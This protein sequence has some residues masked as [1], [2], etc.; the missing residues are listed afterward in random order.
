MHVVVIGGSGNFGARIVRALRADP[1]LRITAASRRGDPVP[2]AEAVPSVALDWK[3]VGFSA[4]LQALL[5]DLVIH[6]V[7][8]F[9]GQDYRVAQAALAA[10]AHYVDLADGRQ[11]V[12]GFAAAV[13]TAARTQDRVAIS[14][15]STLPAL[16]SAVIDDLVEPLASIESID[17]SIA[18]GQRAARGAAT[19]AA[20]FSYLGRPV[21]VWR[22]GNWQRAW[23]WMDLRRIQLDVGHRWGALCDV[24]DLTLFPERYPGVRSVEFHAALEF[25]LQHAALWA[26]AGLRRL[27]LGLSV[28]RWAI[29]MNRWAGW[30]DP[31]A[32]PW[33]GMR[34]S[35]VGRDRG[36]T[37]IRR[38]WQLCAPAQDGPEIPCLAAI[39]LA[40]QIA[41]GRAPKS[42]AYAC[43]GLLRLA[44]FAPAFARWN[45]RTRIEQS[46]ES[47][48]PPASSRTRPP[49]TE[50]RMER[51]QYTVKLLEAY[52]E[53]VAGAV[54]F[55]GLAVAYPGH[56]AFFERCAQGE[57]DM[58]NQM[59]P[60][61]TKYQLTP[62]T[63]A[64]LEARGLDYVRVDA[65]GDALEL[66]RRSV[67]SYARYVE[68]FRALEALGPPE[69]QAI[70]AELTAHEIR[71]IEWMRGRIALGGEPAA[72]PT[73]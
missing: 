17:V 45:I 56:C 59:T 35:V 42:G 57:R 27:G 20:V 9:Q 22:A 16:S 40:R 43:M 50:V 3:A 23:G 34:V 63:A 58:A 53:E 60:L 52:E 19:L 33:G 8:P 61:L 47:N 2:G 10:K 39:L 21:Q 25:K 41:A 70:L 4:R 11:F 51:L 13:Q 38:T 29:G 66:L 62:R 30:F 46:P 37:Q 65:G 5:P 18:P 67:E 26:L 73:H 24:P 64:A 6:C 7:G 68:E 1:A 36:D 48:N 44:D 31:F 15:A 71:L 12:V 28:D 14:G 72:T 55:D 54:Y 69:D 32:G 49:Y